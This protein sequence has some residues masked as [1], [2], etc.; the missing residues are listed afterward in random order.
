MIR[1]WMEGVVLTLGGCWICCPALWL[2]SSRLVLV[3]RHLEKVSGLKYRCESVTLSEASA[4]TFVGSLRK[5]VCNIDEKQQ[6]RLTAFAIVNKISE[7]EMST[8]RK[9]P[10]VQFPP[11]QYNSFRA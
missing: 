1:F 6:W 5:A 8:R 9:T 7:V 4:E 2:W 3:G 10:F 11:M